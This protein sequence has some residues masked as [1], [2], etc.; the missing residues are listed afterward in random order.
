MKTINLPKDVEENSAISKYTIF[1]ETGLVLAQFE[2]EP[3][4]QDLPSQRDEKGNLVSPPT[5][6]GRWTTVSRARIDKINKENFG[7]KKIIK[8]DK[9]TDYDKQLRLAKEALEKL[10]KAQ[11]GNDGPRV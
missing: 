8:E 11:E 7:K 4:K 1:D 5:Y 2:R 3:T 10:L 9:E 6:Y